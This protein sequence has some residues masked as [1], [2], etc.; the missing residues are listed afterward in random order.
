M[1]H[2]HNSNQDLMVMQRMEW[3]MVRNQCRN[4]LRN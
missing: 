1:M 3:I 2:T 4:E